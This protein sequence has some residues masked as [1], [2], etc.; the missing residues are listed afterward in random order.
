MCISVDLDLIVL[1]LCF[2]VRCE[3]G[4]G[5][6]MGRGD[7]CT[8][9]VHCWSAVIRSA[10]NT[11]NRNQS[12]FPQVLERHLNLRPACCTTVPLSEWGCPVVLLSSPDISM[13]LQ[14]AWLVGERVFC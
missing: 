7:V 2:F 10:S 12:V 5:S 6:V 11:R 4:E 8:V 1:F 14:G 13:Q 3:L 9:N